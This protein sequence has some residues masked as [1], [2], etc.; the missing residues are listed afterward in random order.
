MND[1]PPD[2]A[3]SPVF[4][5]GARP[6]PGL[7]RPGSSWSMVLAFAAALLLGAV[8]FVSLNNA[9]QEAQPDVAPAPVAAAPT[10]AIVPT[11]EPAPMVIQAAP[12]PTS[13]AQIAPAPDTRA[14]A[15]VVDFSQASAP[16]PVAAAPAISAA[17]APAPAVPNEERLSADEQFAARSGLGNGNTA[18]AT[19]LR[20]LSRT[21][22][23]GTVIPA[24]LETAIN[25]DLPGFV[26]AVISRDVRGFDGSTV[27]VPRGSKLIG[28]YRSAVA[29]SQTRAFVV[30][31][32]ILTPAGVSI[33]IN[34]PG[35]D[36]LG[37]GGLSGET[38]THFFQR[39]GS[40]ILLSVMSAGLSA[41]TEPSNNTSIIIGS[42]QQAS[43]V[44]GIALQ[45]HV[46]IPVTITVPQG[47]P[48]QV[49]VTRDLDFSGVARP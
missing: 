27:L 7:V 29:L 37:Q 41:L 13:F 28:Q 18:R 36:R 23:Q 19:Q 26:R 15:M 40:A 47:T 38:D 33:E 22:P 49:F 2:L 42:S 44:A 8:T 4:A 14:P 17:G 31:S 21:A 32:R 48:L 12:P 30:W 11:P 5:P 6:H 20:D 45:R 39:F 3:R 1:I 25:S 16:P 10:P 35:T 43:Q 9:R 34:S 46:D 24:I